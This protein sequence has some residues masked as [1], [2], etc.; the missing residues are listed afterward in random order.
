MARTLVA[1]RSNAIGVLLAGMGYTGTTLTLAGIVDEAANLGLTVLIAELP[2]GDSLAIHD[3][4]S[5]RW[6][7]VTS[8]ASSCRS[9]IS[10]TR[11]IASERLFPSIESQWCSSRLEYRTGTRVCWSTMPPPWRRSSIIS[12]SIGR[13]RIGHISGPATWHEAHDRKEGSQRALDK[14]ELEAE[15][16]LSEEGDWSPGS[17]AAAMSALLVAARISTRWWPP[18][19]GWRSGP[20]THCWPRSTHPRGRGGHWLRRHRRSRLVY[21]NTDLGGPATRGDGATGGAEALV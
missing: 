2:E 10:G 20:C 3:L 9:L 16:G 14:H 7:S 8:T 18:T 15:H 6:S 19:T 11:S 21:T 4:P 12:V 17:G 1:R 5:P 13:T